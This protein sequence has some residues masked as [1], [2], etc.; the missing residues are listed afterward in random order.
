PDHACPA[1]ASQ[2][3]NSRAVKGQSGLFVITAV[4]VFTA[5]PKARLEMRMHW[6]PNFPHTPQ[7]YRERV[8]AKA[9]PG[10]ANRPPVPWLFVK[11][12]E[13]RRDPVLRFV[14][15]R[16]E[17]WRPVFVLMNKPIRAHRRRV[18]AFAAV[19][20]ERP[21]VIKP[22]KHLGF[23]VSQIIALGD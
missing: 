3:D 16:D 22:Q 6:N 14:V 20:A 5:D 21:F 4:K 18:H 1:A 23:D 19:V 7:G 2:L 17:H 10:Q 8:I 13:K 11:G 9:P 12:I 15:E